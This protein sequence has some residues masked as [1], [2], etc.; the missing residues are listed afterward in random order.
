MIFI[1]S[2]LFLSHLKY[3]KASGNFHRSEAANDNPN[4]KLRMKGII[5]SRMIIP[6][7]PN[8][9]T[10]IDVLNRIIKLCLCLRN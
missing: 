3:R 1:V 4:I 6:T 7:M 10:R 8:T 9:L 2:H 5:K